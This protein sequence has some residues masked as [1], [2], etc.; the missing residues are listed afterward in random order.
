MHFTSAQENKMEAHEMIESQ[1]F[2]VSTANFREFNFDI[3][4]NPANN[5]LSIQYPSEK[6]VNLK[7]IDLLGNI[8]LDEQITSGTKLVT[9]QLKTGVYFT[10]IEGEGIKASSKKLVIRH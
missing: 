9:E 10:L 8:V 3:A 6:I 5:Y 2:L 4:P 1:E 7:I